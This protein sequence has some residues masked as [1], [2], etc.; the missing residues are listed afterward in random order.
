MAAPYP[1]GAAASR[2]AAPSAPPASS[3]PYPDTRATPASAAPDASEYHTP[4]QLFISCTKLQ[5]KDVLSKS[6]P[7]CVVDM[8]QGTTDPR[9]GQFHEVRLILLQNKI[10]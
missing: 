1:T 2:Y 5:D 10:K 3:A 6:D 4:V 9:R 7:I 8:L